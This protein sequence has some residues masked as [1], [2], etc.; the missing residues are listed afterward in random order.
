[1]SDNNSLDEKQTKLLV[2]TIGQNDWCEAGTRL[3]VDVWSNRHESAGAVRTF[4]CEDGSG[5]VRGLYDGQGTFYVMRF[6]LR[7]EMWTDPQASLTKRDQ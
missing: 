5:Y 3:K 4:L 6:H 7:D 1:M 2:E